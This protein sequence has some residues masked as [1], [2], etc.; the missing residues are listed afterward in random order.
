MAAT[1]K[2]RRPVRTHLPVP[3]YGQPGQCRCG[4]ALDARNARHEHR[5]DLAAIREAELRRLGERDD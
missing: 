2:N 3:A 4:L 1:T 5:L